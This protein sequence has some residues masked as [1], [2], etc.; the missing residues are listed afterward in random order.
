MREEYN[1]LVGFRS[2]DDLSPVGRLWLIF[3]AR[4][5]ASRSFLISFSRTVEAIH[6]PPAPD[7]DIF[8]RPLWSERMNAWALGL[9]QR[10]MVKRKEK[11]W[12]KKGSP[13]LLIKAA[14]IL[15]LPTCPVNSLIRRAT[16]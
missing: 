2:R 14:G 12:V 10:G 15:R 9:E 4:Y 3:L 5:P 8:G 11:A 13:Y 7:P 1:P 16:R 6:L